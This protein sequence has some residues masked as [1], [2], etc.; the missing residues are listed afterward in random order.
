M[1]SMFG[2]TDEE[3]RSLRAIA[4]E[5]FRDWTAMSN[6]GENHPAYPYAQAMRG[7]DK[8]TDSYGA[9]SGDYVVRYFLENARSWR[10]ETARRVKAELRGMVGIK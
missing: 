10:G 6:K 8:V 7:L 3:P 5:I 9:D 4:G 1:S 2:I